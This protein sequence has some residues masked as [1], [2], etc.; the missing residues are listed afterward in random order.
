[1][2]K[3]EVELKRVEFGVT[4]NKRIEKMLTTGEVAK[5]LNVHINTIRRWSNQGL[6]KSYRICSRGDRRFAE[7]DILRYLTENNKDSYQSER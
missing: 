2:I 1:M 7:V 5:L 4:T 3:G 6:I